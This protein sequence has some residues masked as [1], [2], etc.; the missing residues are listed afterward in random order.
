VDM[1]RDSLKSKKKKMHKKVKEPEL[2][3]SF[4][5]NSEMGE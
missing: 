3:E 1:S 2:K 5:A 4:G